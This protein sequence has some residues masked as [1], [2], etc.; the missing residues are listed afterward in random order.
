MYIFFP[1]QCFILWCNNAFCFNFFFYSVL[2]L[3][4][5]WH[6]FWT[7]DMGQQRS[8]LLCFRNMMPHHRQ[9]KVSPGAAPSSCVGKCLGR[10]LSCQPSCQPISGSARRSGGYFVIVLLAYFSEHYSSCLLWSQWESFVVRPL[11][12]FRFQASFDW[13]LFLTHSDVFNIPTLWLAAC[14][15]WPLLPFRWLNYCGIFGF[16]SVNLII[17]VNILCT[18]S[19]LRFQEI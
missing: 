12:E 6:T 5:Q 2:L 13:C 18:I 11:G 1:F 10:R 7:G 8:C 16:Y 3:G 4:F 15:P 19:K 17:K 14:D 9:C